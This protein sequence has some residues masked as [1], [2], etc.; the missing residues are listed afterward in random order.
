MDK[1]VRPLEIVWNKIR[2]IIFFALLTGPLMARGAY[3]WKWIDEEELKPIK[4]FPVILFKCTTT[5]NKL[6]RISYYKGKY[7]YWFGKNNKP[8]LSFYSSPIE[9]FIDEERS[10]FWRKGGESNVYS[11]SDAFFYGDYVYE[12]YSTSV[13]RKEKLPGFPSSESNIYVFKYDEKEDWYQ[14]IGDKKCKE[15]TVIDNFITDEIPPPYKLF[16]N[17]LVEEGQLKDIYKYFK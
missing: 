8:E 12:I 17:Q 14:K 11:S 6:V 7:Q 13:E 15:E 1:Y 5:N 10:K 3:R 2:L 16:K 4:V 9:I